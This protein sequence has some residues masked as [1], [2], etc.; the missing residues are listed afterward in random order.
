[1][2]FMLKE[3][4]W[5]AEDCVISNCEMKALLG[6]SPGSC[7]GGLEAV[8]D[9]AGGGIVEC[10]SAIGGACRASLEPRFAYE[11]SPICR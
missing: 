4:C 5:F 1:M 11:A 10:P 2:A 9:C 7:G 8:G 3:D 6:T